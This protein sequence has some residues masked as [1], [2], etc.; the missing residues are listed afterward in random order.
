MMNDKEE[1]EE[2]VQL[3]W[4]GC[5]DYDFLETVKFNESME[6]HSRFNEGALWVKGEKHEPFNVIKIDDSE[7]DKDEYGELIIPSDVFI[8]ASS[9]NFYREIK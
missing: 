5:D 3:I 1:H 6:S 7:I 9:N 8:P 2:V 4:N